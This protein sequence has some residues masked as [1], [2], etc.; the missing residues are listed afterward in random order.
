MDT[1]YNSHW[2]DYLVFGIIMSITV[3]IG[4]LFATTGGKQRT[5][6][7]Y[8]TGDRNMRVI[9]AALSIAVTYMSSILVI[10]VPAEAYLYGGQYLLVS[11]GFIT[12]TTLA[13]LFIVPIIYPL[14]LVSVNSVSRSVFF[15]AGPC[16]FWC[17]SELII[18][19]SKLMLQQ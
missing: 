3:A 13:A 5:T 16:T 18:C 6:G 1:L 2:A 4:V 7:E 11:I 9:P 17:V 12:G 8:F 14:K 15:I 19:E 10:G